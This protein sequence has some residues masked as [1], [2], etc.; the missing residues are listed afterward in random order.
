[1]V[2]VVDSSAC[3]STNDNHVSTTIALPEIV[4]DSYVIDDSLGNGNGFIDCD[5]F[6]CSGHLGDSN[7]Y[8]KS[9]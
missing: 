1:M 5:D 8:S 7:I 9:F 2:Q 6:Q 4:I 3:V